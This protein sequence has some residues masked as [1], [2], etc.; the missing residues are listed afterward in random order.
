MGII[1][2]PGWFAETVTASE[3]AVRAGGERSASHAA[4][5][6]KRGRSC[7]GLRWPSARLAPARDDITGSTS[8]FKGCDIGVC[9]YRD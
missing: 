6:T 5:S 1:R 3:E 7:Y 4:S 8:C 2:R 9:I